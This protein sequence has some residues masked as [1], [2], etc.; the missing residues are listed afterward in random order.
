MR[1]H[2]RV[3]IERVKTKAAFSDNVAAGGMDVAVEDIQ[4]KDLMFCTPIPPSHM[5]HILPC[6][7][8]APLTHTNYLSGHGPS[9]F[10]AHPTTALPCELCLS[11]PGF[12]G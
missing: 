6:I 4:L 3:L 5:A 9:S 10:L 12:W 8:C 1:S 7:R 2:R 11:T